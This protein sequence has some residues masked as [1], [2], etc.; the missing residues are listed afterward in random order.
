M[1]LGEA[2]PPRARRHGV[3]RRTCRDRGT[4]LPVLVPRSERRVRAYT[5]VLREVPTQGCEMLE[6]PIRLKAL[7]VRPHGHGE[8]RQHAFFG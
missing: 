2:T 8:K 4:C 3:L 7:S 5:A 1:A 6:L